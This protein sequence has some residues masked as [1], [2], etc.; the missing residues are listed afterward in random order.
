MDTYETRMAALKEVVEQETAALRRAQAFHARVQTLREKRADKAPT[1]HT[2]RVDL[3]HV[4]TH[5]GPEKE[6]V[7][8]AAE[9][10]VRARAEQRAAQTTDPELA[11]AAWRREN[12]DY[13]YD[14]TKERDLV[15]KIVDREDRSQV[16]RQYP[17]QAEL[18]YRRA[19]R[20]FLEL[21]GL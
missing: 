15:I 18:A 5:A 3:H 6:P 8:T 21:I 19:F 7:A 1:G 11:G 4:E 9:E 20:K 16:L 12:T 2:D 10:A 13:D 17:N 14:L